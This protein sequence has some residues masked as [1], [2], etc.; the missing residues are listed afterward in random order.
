MDTAY[1]AKR[2]PIRPGEVIVVYT[3]GITDAMNQ[4][5][6]RFGDEHL[7]RA[8]SEAPDSVAAAGPAILE[9]VRR[10]VAGHARFDDMT[11]ICF[12]RT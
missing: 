2:V 8:L 3:D 5:D 9:A 10:H 4:H 6:H 7:R 1:E 11:L 12:G